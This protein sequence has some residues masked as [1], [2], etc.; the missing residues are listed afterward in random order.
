M[1]NKLLS[2]DEIARNPAM[3]AAQ[4]AHEIA[5]TRIAAHAAA[6]A[7]DAAHEAAVGEHGANP[8]AQ[9]EPGWL[10]VTET[11][12]AYPVKRRFLFDNRHDL[13]FIRN[14]SRKTILVNER[15]LLRWLALRK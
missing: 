12:A 4:P 1:I 6:A 3:L 13:P 14:V 9:A 11:E 15:G 10:T 7:L 8:A 5:E 2:L